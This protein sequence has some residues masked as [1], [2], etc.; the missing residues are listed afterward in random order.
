MPKQPAKN[1]LPLPVALDVLVGE[2]PDCGLGDGEP[3]GRLGAADL[4]SR[5]L[6]RP[7]HG[8]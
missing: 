8:G 1:L 3:H 2:E 5:L 7:R 6:W 4:E